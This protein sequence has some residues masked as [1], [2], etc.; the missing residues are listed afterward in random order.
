MH[1]MQIENCVLCGKCLNVCPIFNYTLK[2]EDS[3]R[4]KAFLYN[5]IN[6]LLISEKDIKKDLV[7]C[8]GCAR[9]YD[10]C[11]QRIYIPDVVSDLRARYRDLKSRLYSKAVTALPL[12]PE[13]IVK[14][15]NE[16]KFAP[17]SSMGILSIKEKGSKINEKVA[18]FAGCFGKYIRKDLINKAKKVLDS[19]F[20]SVEIFQ[21]TC[22][23]YPFYFAGDKNR[24]KRSFQENFRLWNEL[25]RPKIITFCAT[26]YKA[27]KRYEK[28]ISDEMKKK[29]WI[30]SIHYLSE[31]ITPDGI[32]L[33]KSPPDLILHKPCHL[34]KDFF[35]NLRLFFEHMNLCNKIIDQCCGFGGCTRLEFSELCNGIGKKFWDNVDEKMVVTGCSGCIIQLALTKDNLYVGHWLDLIL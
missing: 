26:C 35:E 9:C 30:N 28:F 29:V 2:E 13:Y 32:E 1:K 27:L 31:F 3:P 14:I 22:C 24:E 10:V 7:K 17:S 5:K 23:G 8:L 6:E 15:L 20:E 21:G 12:L 11:P 18:L 19:Y 4:A 34:E 33:V 25:G 16:K